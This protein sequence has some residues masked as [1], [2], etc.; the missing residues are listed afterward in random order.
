VAGSHVSVD[1]G[2]KQREYQDR[3]GEAGRD[4]AKAIRF[5]LSAAKREIEEGVLSNE[6]EGQ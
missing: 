4:R 3:P 5:A 2:W 6:V 1:F